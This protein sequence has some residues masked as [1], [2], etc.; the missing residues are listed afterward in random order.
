[1]PDNLHKPTGADWA[2]LMPKQMIPAANLMSHPIGA[3]AAVSALGFGIASHMLGLWAG[4]MASAFDM[5]SS[6]K[7]E[8]KDISAGALPHSPDVDALKSI[9]REKV[10]TGAESIASTATPAA[11]RSKLPTDVEATT[12]YQR[13]EAAVAV[14]DLKQISGIGPK[15]EK[16]LNGLGI[17]TYAHIAAWTSADLARIDD[18]LK[19]NGRISRDDWVGQARMLCPAGRE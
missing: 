17:L 3:A 13:L 19:L 11:A 6:F 7:R 5:N 8:T 1:M 16:V 18:Q 2:A 15:L 9:I 4:T 14:D 12:P 10:G